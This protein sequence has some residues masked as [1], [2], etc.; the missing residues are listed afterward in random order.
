MSTKG[1]KQATSEP[2]KS[3]LYIFCDARQ[4]CLRQ[5]AAAIRKLGCKGKE[6]EY[7]RARHSNVGSLLKEQIESGLQPNDDILVVVPRI[8]D[9]QKVEVIQALKS[10]KKTGVNC[11]W[12]HGPKWFDGNETVAT[13]FQGIPSNRSF[14]I[15]ACENKYY[16]NDPSTDSSGDADIISYIDYRL[17][18]LFMGADTEQNTLKAIISA[19]SK[20]EEN[21]FRM[22]KDEDNAMSTLVEGF[23]MVRPSMA[24]RSAVFEQHKKRIVDLARLD[25]NVMIIGKTGTGKEATAYYLHEFSPRRGK[26]FVAVNC[27]CFTEE[28]LISELF[29]HVRG[30]FTGAVGDKKGLVESLHGGTLFLDEIPDAS[31]RIQAMLLRFLQSGEYSPAGSN[32]TRRV[33]V[34]IVAGAQP[35]LLDKLRSDLQY[36]LEER[37]HTF[38][39][40]ELN[41]I[42]RRGM[43][44]KSYT[45]QPDIVSVARNLAASCIGKCKLGG[46][47]GF[48]FKPDRIAHSD[49]VSFWDLTEQPEIVELLT[50]YDWPGNVREL[51]TCVSRHLS[52]GVEMA[53]IVRQ[54]QKSACEDG[55]RGAN[56]AN[57]FDGPVAFA[58]ITSAEDL[59]PFYELENRYAEFIRAQRESGPLKQCAA[60]ILRNKLGLSP[61]T[62]RQYIVNGEKK[63]KQTKT[64]E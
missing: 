39:L 58:P 8:D 64:K 54:L 17:M 44:D 63:Q 20:A 1:A 12:Y 31:L 16:K 27:A 26:N 49:I 62:Y 55:S 38:S 46:E 45:G 10:L 3:K 34:K 48:T 32:D 25:K 21:N 59:I 7:R 14:T 24:G 2:S 13:I 30:A 11:Y 6:T 15:E 5:A 33:D 22:P 52:E 47:G 50:G 43:E 51:Q 53:E 35:G 40:K 57:N 56:T 37:L 4:E 61:N 60:N 41:D 18:Y 23:A 29:G 28:L 42:Y 19:L 36:R 9:D